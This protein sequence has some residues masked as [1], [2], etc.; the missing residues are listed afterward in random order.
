VVTPDGDNGATPDKDVKRLIVLWLW[1]VFLAVFLF[2]VGVG[3][4]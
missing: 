1:W 3:V 4:F 2:A